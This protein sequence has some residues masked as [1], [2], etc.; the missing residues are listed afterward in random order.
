MAIGLVAVFLG[1]AIGKMIGDM[2]QTALRRPASNG[3]NG[4]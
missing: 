4:G 1:V 2:L 3:G